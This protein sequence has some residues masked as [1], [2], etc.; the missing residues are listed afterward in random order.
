M[1]GLLLACALSLVIAFAAGAAPVIR[2]P[3]PYLPPLLRFENGSQVVDEAGW[4]Q[5]RHEVSRLA[6]ETFLGTYPADVPPLSSHRIINV[7]AAGEGVSCTFVELTFDTSRGGGAVASVTLP[8]EI[9]APTD[10]ARRPVF[11][12]Q[13]NHRQ[14]ALEGVARGYIGVVY[15]GSDAKDV[16]PLFQQAYPQSSFA[17]IT[18]RAFVGSRCLDFILA[19]WPNVN[20][21]QVALTGH[22]RNVNCKLSSRGLHAIRARRLPCHCKAR[23]VFVLTWLWELVLGTQGKQSLVFAALDERVTATVGSSPGVPIASPYHFSSENYYGESPRTG[24]VTCK[25]PK[26][27]LCS[28]LEY[29][30]HPERMPMDGHGIL[31][32]CA[33]RACAIATVRCSMTVSV[34]VMNLADALRCYR[35]IKTAVTIPTPTRCRSRRH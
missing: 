28:S 14:W 4:R 25:G 19:H 20:P 16:A 26:W 35:P 30:G 22:S 18:A 29:D 23:G 13:W 33:P 32:L 24:G 17:L 34:L 5:R 21:Q 2:N 8:L 6:Q 27:W 9:I 11:L 3:S 1:I 10:N 15:P 12:T 31:G 7:T